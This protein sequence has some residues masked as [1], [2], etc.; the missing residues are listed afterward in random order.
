[1]GV[2]SCSLLQLWLQDVLWVLGP[3]DQTSLLLEDLASPA[4]PIEIEIKTEK[5]KKGWRWLRRVEEREHRE[6]KSW[7]TQKL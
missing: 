4:V 3:L 1:M 5:A 6:E 2:I 7:T